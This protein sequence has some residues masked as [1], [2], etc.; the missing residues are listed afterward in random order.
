MTFEAYMTNIRTQTGKEPK[1]F[2]DQAVRE[3]ILR[4]DTRTMEF[5]AWLKSSSGLGHGHAMA[6]WE[7]FRRNGWVPLPGAPAAAVK[8]GSP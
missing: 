5:V 4:P 3:G 8:R 2:F 6:V 7:A 1:D